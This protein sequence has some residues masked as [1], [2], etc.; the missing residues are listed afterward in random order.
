[1]GKWNV[2]L[3]KFICM[4]IV[5][6]AIRFMMLLLNENSSRTLH[7]LA[8]AHNFKAIS[9]ALVGVT[10]KLNSSGKARPSRTH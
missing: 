10:I 6:D 5:Y 7:S 4:L 2:I 1:M 8:T 9:K 3:L